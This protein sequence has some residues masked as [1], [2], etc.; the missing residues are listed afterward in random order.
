MTERAQVTVWR[1]VQATAVVVVLGFFL[2]E[3]LAILNPALLFVVLWAVLLP[4]RGR[5]GHTALVAISA[6]LTGFWLLSETGTLLGPFVLALVLAYI[7]DPLVDRVAARGLSRSLAVLALMVPAVALLAA[8]VL[9]LVPAA[10]GQLGGVLQAAPVLFDRLGRWIELGQQN[11]LTVD[12]PLIDGEDIVARLRAVDAAAVVVFLQERQAALAA[13]VWGGVLGLRRGFGSILTIVGYVVLTPVLTF[14]LIRDWDRL[15][16]WIAELVPER[17]R[18]RFVSFFS[19]CDDLVSS[20]L[21]GQV[22]VAITIGLITGVGLGIVQFPY[23]AS[24]GVM[25]GI[26]SVVPYLGLVV[27]LVPAIFIALVSGSVGV[28]LLK[29]AVVYGVAQLLD[30]TVI[31]PRIVGGSV[32]IH[33]VWVVLALSLGGFFFGLVGLLIGVPAAAVTKLLIV[34]GLERYRESELYRGSELPADG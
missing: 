34:R 11:L 26:F 21:R 24:L 27:S 6:I 19:E 7:L 31:T 12:V 18:D 5:E 23:A 15:T 3:T 10:F 25:V 4:F 9:I 17:S 32:G 8:V 29:I 1:I 16:A 20:Y 2:L 28:S 13:Y 22:T 33:P 14:Y 30:G